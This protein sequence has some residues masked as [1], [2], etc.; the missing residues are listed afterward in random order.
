MKTYVINFLVCALKNEVTTSATSK[1]LAYP[2]TIIVCSFSE[3]V[4]GTIIFFIVVSNYV[5]R[6]YFVRELTHLFLQKVIEKF[7]YQIKSFLNE[8]D[9][10]L[11]SRSFIRE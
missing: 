3:N 8:S 5:N 4:T 7:S 9:V 11:N 10:K 2:V 6:F 1:I